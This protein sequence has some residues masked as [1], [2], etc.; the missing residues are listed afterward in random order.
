MRKRKFTLWVVAV[1]FVIIGC[2]ESDDP[3]PLDPA[4]TAQEIIDTA[5]SGTW[6]VTYFFDTDTDETSNF[7]GY[8]FTF[9]ANGS[10]DAVNGNTTVTGTWSVT[11]GSSSSMDD[12][13]FVLFFASPP[14]FEDL[15][16]DW[17]I[18]SLSNSKIELTDVSGGNG[19]TDFLTFEKN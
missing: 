15:S 18:V 2:S 10:V 1:L 3:A 19:G 12:D 13:H 7:S 9:N 6:R 8:N 17:T 5:Q 4:A 11:P 14:D 16:D